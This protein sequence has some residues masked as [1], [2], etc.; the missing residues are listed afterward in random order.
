M[1]EIDGLSV[2]YGAVDALDGV[3]LTVERGGITAV[4]GA[5][6]AGKTTLLRTISGLQP[7]RAGRISWN[8]EELTGR[9]PDRIARGGVA[10]VPEGGGVITELT[11]DENLRLGALWRRDRAD[12]AAARDEVYEL[13]PPLRERSGKFAS[14]LSGGERQ[15]LAIGR[16]L[17]S[18]PGL[19]LLDEPSLGLAPLITARIMGI[20][21][22]LR[23]STGLTVVLV[24]QNAHSALSIAD[25][26]Y[27]LAL[28][29][30]VAVDTAAEL[31]ADDG[32]RHA[33]LGF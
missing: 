33:Y 28:G 9:A 25:R 5:N 8:G 24:E 15:M 20:L 26:G 29:R 30:V 27:V 32:L 7:A 31:L 18:R 10:H 12:R 22:D 23:A 1:L 2:A 16:A 11:V 6:G 13:F 3:G 19:L 14:T 17:M 4:L 21:R